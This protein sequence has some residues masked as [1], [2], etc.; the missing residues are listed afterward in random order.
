MRT[1]EITVRDSG[2]N[3]ANLSTAFCCEVSHTKAQTQRKKG[4]RLTM[5]RQVADSQNSVDPD[6]LD[7]RYVTLCAN[8]VLISRFILAPQTA[9]AVN[10]L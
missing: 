1:V 3:L 2:C 5:L 4:G 7:R 9:P 10:L 6:E 8:E